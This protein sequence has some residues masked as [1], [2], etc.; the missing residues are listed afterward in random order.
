MSPEENWPPLDV[1][2]ASGPNLCCLLESTIDQVWHAYMLNPGSVQLRS[3]LI[4]TLTCYEGDMQKTAPGFQ[5]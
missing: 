2:M 1:I 3:E 4:I 5:L